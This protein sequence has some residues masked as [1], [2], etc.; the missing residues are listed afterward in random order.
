MLL[1]S[2]SAYTRI[3]MEVDGLTD[4]INFLGLMCEFLSTT[5]LKDELILR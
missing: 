4:N 5:S 1:Q 3:M 2:I